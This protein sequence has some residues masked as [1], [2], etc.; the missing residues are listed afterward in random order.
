MPIP[1]SPRRDPLGMSLCPS[2]GRGG[3]FW[4][5]QLAPI[6]TLLPLG[7]GGGCGARPQPP[8]AT[9]PQVRAGGEGGSGA[10]SG[11]CWGG[12]LVWKPP[13]E[14]PAAPSCPTSL[15]PQHGSP[16]PATFLSPPT[17][18]P[19]PAHSSLLPPVRPRPHP[20]ARVRWRHAARSQW[21][22]RT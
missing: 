6:P 20:S 11:A 10:R 7:R 8:P 1:S 15:P 2:R 17:L 3:G 4:G 22:W 16:T 21:E 5:S 9:A 13:G 18:V 12:I 19:V 14:W